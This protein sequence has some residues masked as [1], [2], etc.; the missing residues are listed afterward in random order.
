MLKCSYCIIADDELSISS[1]LRK[2]QH[3]FHEYLM[4]FFRLGY[5]TL[6]TATPTHSNAVPP[7]YY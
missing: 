7:H 1:N 4:N 2:N 3:N 5:V 6:P